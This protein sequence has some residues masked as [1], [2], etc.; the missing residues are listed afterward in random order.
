LALLFSFVGEGPMT[1]SSVFRQIALSLDGTTEA[2]HF[3]RQAFKVKRIYATL[4]AD[5]KSANLKLTPDEQE[6]KTMLAPEAFRAIDNAWG[7]QGWTTAYLDKLGE[8]ELRAALE[9]AH[10]HALPPPKGK[11]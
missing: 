3:D 10:A 5:G 11:K 2:A 4:A 9:M 1:S 6:F 8:T 7:R